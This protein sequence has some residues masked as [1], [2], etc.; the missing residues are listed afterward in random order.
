M[1]I[2]VSQPEKSLQIDRDDNEDVKM[3]KLAQ[4]LH[5]SHP[6]GFAFVWV[7]CDA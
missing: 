7:N 3:L 5:P 2:F 4:S 1:Q 6:V